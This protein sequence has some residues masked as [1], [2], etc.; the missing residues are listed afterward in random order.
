MVVSNL[1]RCLTR[2]R[3][4]H[5][6]SKFSNNIQYLPE[7]STNR[8]YKPPQVLVYHSESL[9]MAYNMKEHSN[10]FFYGAM[11]AVPQQCSRP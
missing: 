6:I 10:L 1:K 2:W 4:N 5:I 7:I 3:L 11:Y 8:L 9:V